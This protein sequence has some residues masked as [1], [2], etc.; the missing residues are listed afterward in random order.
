MEGPLE[1]HD[2]R[3]YDSREKLSGMN[4]VEKLRHI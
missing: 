3:R 2:A 1:T 4:N